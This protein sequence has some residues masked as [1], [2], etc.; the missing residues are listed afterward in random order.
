MGM[1][2]REICDALHQAAAL[3]RRGW[4]QHA[5]AKTAE[6]K[7]TSPRAPDAASWC[8]LGAIQK[9]CGGPEDGGEVRRSLREVLWP[10]EVSQWNDGL[11]RNA[12]EV[13]LKLEEAASITC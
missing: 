5:L 2:G 6:G 12:E 1:S 3:V 10:M 8:A 11:A 7:P 13:A 4:C 9:I